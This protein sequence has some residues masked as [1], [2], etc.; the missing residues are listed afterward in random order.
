MNLGDG[1][2]GATSL[3]DSVVEGEAARSAGGKVLG[4]DARRGIPRLD[5]SLIEVGGAAVGDEGKLDAGTDQFAL[6]PDGEGHLLADREIR[7]AFRNRGGIGDIGS[8]GLGGHREGE[9]RPDLEAADD[10]G[11]FRRG[12]GHVKRKQGGEER[13]GVK[14]QC[15]HD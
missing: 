13:E 7:N 10:G 6:L 9:G 5:L 1:E 11:W 12:L 8:R 4:K 14:Q 3:G 15:F 2:P